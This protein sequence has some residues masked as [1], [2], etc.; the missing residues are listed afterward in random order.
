MEILL[1][2]I[3]GIWA[4]IIIL[5]IIAFVILISCFIVILIEWLNRRGHNSENNKKNM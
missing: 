4:L 3:I 5:S 2:I 1:S